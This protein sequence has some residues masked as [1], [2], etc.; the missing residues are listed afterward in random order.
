MEGE[1]STHFQYL[2]KSVNE[3]SWV[4]GLT[5]RGLRW[6]RDKQFQG[7]CYF[8]RPLNVNL[9]NHPFW[10]L[11]AAS[12]RKVAG[13]GWWSRSKDRMASYS[14]LD[15]DFCWCRR[16]FDGDHNFMAWFY[17]VLPQI[18]SKNW[19]WNTF[20]CCVIDFAQAFIHNSSLHQLSQQPRCRYASRHCHS[21]YLWKIIK[22][23]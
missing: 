7:Q 12:L 14:L 1:C 22:N 18:N 6:K 19:R 17:L 21:R 16:H 20:H 8:N 15:L 2:L 13:S 4:N 23:V 10:Y 9:Q 11:Q 5:G 3:L